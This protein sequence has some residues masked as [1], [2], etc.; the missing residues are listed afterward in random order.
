M[1]PVFI[2]WLSGFLICV[3]VISANEVNNQQEFDQEMEEE[4]NEILVERFKRSAEPQP[5]AKV[6]RGGGSRSSFRSSSRRT[7]LLGVSYHGI[8]VTHRANCVSVAVAVVV[9]M[10]SLCAFFG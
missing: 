1:K 2:L 8:G 3:V 5:R 6:S 7:G 10:I 9:V 4:V